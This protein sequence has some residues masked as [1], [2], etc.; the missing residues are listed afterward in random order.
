[1]YLFS[2]DRFV[3]ILKKINNIYIWSLTKWIISLLIGW[4]GFI[5]IISNGS[6]INN[7]EVILEDYKFIDIDSNYS[8]IEERESY[9]LFGSI[10]YFFGRLI[11]M[12][13]FG[14]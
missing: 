11:L 7:I 3:D 5:Y 1:M 9:K 8:L 4:L 12:L 13:I 6:D 14:L 10:I 2:I